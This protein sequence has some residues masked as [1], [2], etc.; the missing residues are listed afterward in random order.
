MLY[1]VITEE[2]AELVAEQLYE[3]YLF[4]RTAIVKQFPFML[5]NNIWKGGKEL[6]L[7]DRLED[8]LKQ[9][10]LGIG[11]IGLAEA[12]KMLIGEHHGESRNNFV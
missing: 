8:I 5:T 11:F 10:T 6:G 7:G 3:R 9:G 1:E 12:L 2:T 4:Q